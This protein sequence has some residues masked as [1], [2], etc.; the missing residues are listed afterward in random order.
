[1]AVRLIAAVTDRGRSL[2]DTLAREFAADSHGSLDA[3]A[4]R[5]KGLARLIAATVLRQK[6]QL[7]A[8]IGSFLEKP[9]PGDRGQASAILQAAAAQLLFLDIA[10]HAVI[11]IAVEQ[12]RNDGKARRFAKL[13]NAVLRR[14]A[15]HGRSM[16]ATT[17]SE[18]SNIPEWMWSRW[19][20][21][22][23]E[24]TT[25]RIAA[26][27]LREAALDISIKNAGSGEDLALWAE[28]LGGEV[29]ATGS[30]RLLAHARVDELPGF[31]DGEWWVQD[32]AAALPA[33]LMG[34]VKGRDVAELCAAPGG[35]TA[36]LAAGGARV[37]AIDLSEDR[38]GRL[39]ANLQRLGLDAQLIA[40][41]ATT[42][43]PGRQFD[44]V[45]L[46]AP[47]S[48]TGTI[49]RHPDI[50]HLK[51]AADIAH[52]AALQSRLLDQAFT[53]VRPGGHVVY[54]TCS[55]EPE[56]GPQQIGRFLERQP[57]AVRDTIAAS[58]LAG[59]TGGDVAAIAEMITADGDLRTMPFH[60]PHAEPRLA[61][62]DGF[63]A[64]RLKRI[65]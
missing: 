22:Y 11:N 16:L 40:T 6:G 43:S 4:P 59:T 42:W 41:D 5:D 29:L 48:A 38:L 13:V 58:E 7:D 30:I 47:C 14:V 45:L 9:L 53:L 15:E 49:R 36:Q 10:P 25:E 55:L 60:L 65:S 46:D 54:C 2:D 8:V 17:Q 35:K 33:R 32:A 37:T 1:M 12:C 44:A 31:E 18:R 39:R 64:A 52:L 62:L 19:V 20:A 56:E 57:D 26:A 50:P 63:F 23:G 61:G 21:A 3:L 24:T 51:R 28:R 27:S 34:N